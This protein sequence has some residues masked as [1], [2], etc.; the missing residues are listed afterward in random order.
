[1][2]REKQYQST[3]DRLRHSRLAQGAA[4]LLAATIAAGCSSSSS[5][6]DQAG[7]S[8]RASAVAVG[9]RTP[10][11]AAAPSSQAPK[12]AASTMPLS[13][14]CQADNS[15]IKKAFEFGSDVNTEADCRVPSTPPVPGMPVLRWDIGEFSIIVDKTTGLNGQVM[16]ALEQ[17]NS[18]KVFTV[19]GDTG[20]AEL[21]VARIDVGLAD[22]TVAQMEAQGPF[23]SVARTD[24][25]LV[26]AA[27]ILL[28]FNGINPYSTPIAG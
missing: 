26:A 10:G 24:A 5:S 4:L 21:G 28:N 8:G 6:P 3:F 17:E 16:K 1:M 14:M 12:P 15:V 19:G 11:P 27:S 20:V 7:K 22:G 18:G 13:E 9:V 2:T 25:A 23:V